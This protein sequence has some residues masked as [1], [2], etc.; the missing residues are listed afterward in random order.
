MGLHQTSVYMGTIGGGVFAGLIG[1]YYGWRWSFIVFGAL[2]IVLGV[3]LQGLLREPKRGAADY[4]DAGIEGA[5]APP[6]RKVPLGEFLS[7]IWRTP[8]ALI[9]MGAFTCANFVGVVLLSWMP[10]YLAEDFGMSLGWAGLTATLYVQLASMLAAPLG[11]WIADNLR[12]RT[13]GGRMMVQAIGAF[14]GAP[15]VALCGLTQ[16][17]GVLIVAL[18]AWGFFKG[19]YDANIF[20]SI[21]DVIRP[22][23]RGTAAGFMNTVGWLGGGGTAPII[24]GW[25]A[26]RTGLG[27]AIATAS[28]VYVAAGLLLTAGV[29]FTVRRDSERMIQSLSGAAQVQH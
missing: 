11:G 15:F 29:L 23:A 27:F 20:A 5:A 26:M 3:V 8:T 19:L 6:A 4:A 25:I 24:I 1:E 18:T 13:A 9:L 21:F 17:V 22:E 16:E 2:G 12:K 14:G 10:A 28:V 7:Q